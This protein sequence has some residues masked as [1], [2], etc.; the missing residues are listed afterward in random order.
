MQNGKFITYTSR[1]LKTHEKNYPTHDLKLEVVFV[2][3]IWG[4]YLCGAHAYCHD[5]KYILDMTW[6]LRS[7]M[8]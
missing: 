6:Q 7:Q 4:N 5:L 1:Q 8:P 2:L 3:K